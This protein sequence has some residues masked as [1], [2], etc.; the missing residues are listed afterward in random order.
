MNG[1]LR[2]LSRPSQRTLEPRC[3]AGLASLLAIT[4][5]LLAAGCGED[6][7]NGTPADRIGV[8]A[9]CDQDADCPEVEIGDE[10]VQLSCLT[11]FDAGYCALEGC[12]DRLDCPYGATC[13]R[14]TDGVNYCFRECSGK[15]EC[16][17]NR[18]RDAEANC[19][20]SFDYANAADEVSGLK[21][22]IPP[23]SG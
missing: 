14:H 2:Q 10:L 8:A 15:W 5:L 19:S 22:C 20:S 18:P 9:I 23:S 11:Q 12:D 6:D 21:A 3:R 4:A 17:A 16:N 7:D 1:A 13:V